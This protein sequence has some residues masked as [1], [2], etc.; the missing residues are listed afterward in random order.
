PECL[1]FA[2]CWRGFLDVTSWRSRRLRARR[3]HRPGRR[4]L[5]RTTSWPGRRGLLKRCADE[6]VAVAAI[7]TIVG[8]KKTYA[9]GLVAL[10][11]IDLEI[12][13]GEIFALLGP[14]GAGKTTLIS[15]VCGIVNASGGRV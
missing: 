10:R 15:I 12:H 2:K 5:S 3:H 9:S 7:L 13:K 11:N 14:N 1:A 6:G 4:H 8:L